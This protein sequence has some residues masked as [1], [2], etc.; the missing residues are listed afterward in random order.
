MRSIVLAGARSCLIA[1]LAAGLLNLPAMAAAEKPL[2]VVVSADHASLDN[3]KAAMGADVYFG[4]AIATETNGSLR[5]KVG[6]GQVYLLASSSATLAPQ[7]NRVRAKVERGTMGFSTPSPDQLEIET[8]LGVV[9]GA[10]HQSIFGQVTVLSST[11]I[12]VSS[13]QGTLLVDTGNG[14][15]KTIEQGQTYEA[16]LAAGPAPGG[17]QNSAGVGGSGPNWKHIAEVGATIG[18]VAILACALTPESSTERDGGKELAC[19]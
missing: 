13:Y 15:E 17:A 16:S 10:N 12:R 14:L 7:D 2:G 9:R 3:A 19:F 11:K 6:S 1:I 5:L 8:P 18:T 4:D